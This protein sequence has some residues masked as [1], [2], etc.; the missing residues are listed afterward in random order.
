MTDRDW[1]IYGFDDRHLGR[2]GSARGENAVKSSMRVMNQWYN[3]NLIWK[4]FYLYPDGDP[5][6]DNLL[7]AGYVG[8]YMQ[9]WDAPYR[10]GKNSIS[11]ALHANVSPDADFIV[12]N[13]FPNNAGKPWGVGGP[14]V[15]RKVFFPVSNK[16]PIASLLYLDWLHSRDNLFFM[17][18][19]ERGVTHEIMPDGVLKSITV[20]GE[21]I[22][23]S[24]FNI[25]YT[26]FINGIRMS[27]A[28]LERKSRVLS[29]PEVNP[30]LIERAIVVALENYTIFGRANV[31]PI[32]SEEGMGQVL[33]EKRDAIYARAIQAPVAQF[34]SVFDSGYRDWLSSGGQAIINERTAKWKEFYGDKT[35]VR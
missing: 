11:A 14:S 3:E 16:N 12:M 17:Q 25:D 20:T 27:T 4:D 34:D 30:A 32:A 5:T 1:F 13:P 24:P 2:P 35:S 9:N 10:D 18:F 26:T 19:G 21:K 15:D 31:G 22:M 8:A 7:R 29:Y 23:N 28:E 33:K 6:Q